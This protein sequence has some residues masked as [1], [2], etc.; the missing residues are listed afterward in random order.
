MSKYNILTVDDDETV[1]AILNQTL[2]TNGY[3]V[4]SANNGEKALKILESDTSIDGIIL[5]I[6]M[7]GMDGKKTLKAIKSNDT[8]KDIPIMMLSGEN[9]ISEVSECLSMG[10]NDYM[11]K[12]F[13]TESLLVRLE[14]LLPKN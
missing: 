6:M 5:D 10:A 14:V 12:P 13:N 3:D 8:T 4:T 7:P 2:E 9:A 1:L 11:V